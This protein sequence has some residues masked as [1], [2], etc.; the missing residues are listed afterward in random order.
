MKGFS[1]KVNIN[2]YQLIMWNNVIYHP[3]GPPS[4]EF[5]QVIIRLD[6]QFCFKSGPLRSTPVESGPESVE[7]G[8]T[9][10]NSGQIRSD[11][12]NSGRIRS[13]SGTLPSNPVE[14]P[15][16][17]VKLDPVRSPVESGTGFNS[18]I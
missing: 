17:P 5:R 6:D 14:L 12:G 4:F 18:S 8:P 9:P 11:S 2:G 15:S 1:G 16:N 13:D 3:F 7:S 10:V